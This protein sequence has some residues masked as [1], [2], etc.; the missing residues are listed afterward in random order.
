MN[1][2][3][4]SMTGVLKAAEKFAKSVSE[5]ASEKADSL[6][7]QAKAYAPPP[8]PTLNDIV[9]Q[10]E[11]TQCKLT[12]SLMDSLIASNKCRMC[13]RVFCAKCMSK[14]AVPVP[15]SLLHESFRPKISDDKPIPP[16]EK[17]SL[18]NMECLPLAVVACMEKFRKEVNEQ[19]AP[20]FDR[21]L[22]DEEQQDFFELPSAAPK[23]TAFR[24]A[25][26]F[27]QIAEKI[28]DFTS[29]SQ[30]LKAVK[31]AY[32]G[33][34]LINVLVAGDLFPVLS[35]MMEALKRF[36]ITGPMALLR[37]YYLGCKHT[38]LAKQRTQRRALYYLPDK[39]G[40]LLSSCPLPVLQYVSQYVSAAQW[41]YISRLPSPHEGNDWNS[42]YLAK[43]IARQGWTL[44]LCVNDSTKLINGAKCPAF[45][46][47]ARC[48]H[49]N[50]EAML[51]IRGS[52]STMDW[53]INFE[54][55]MTSY[56]Y[57]YYHED[58][59]LTV[60]D[61]M[62]YGV[63]K[64]SL[65]ILDGYH[66]RS[67]LNRLLD[68]GYDLKIV[69]H[70]LGGAVASCIAAELRSSRILQSTGSGQQAIKADSAAVFNLPPPT[71]QRSPS[72]CPS[73]AET[74]SL[75][76][77]ISAVL[78]SCPAYI[79]PAL[80][81]AF[82]EDR[83]LINVINGSD[84]VPRFCYH[85]LGLLAEE[86][87]EFLPQSQV[88]MEEDKED[89]KDYVSNMGR[90]GD[91][92]TATATEDHKAAR[93][94]RMMKA[95][96]RADK[97]TQQAAIAAAEATSKAQEAEASKAS[98]A[99]QAEAAAANGGEQSMLSGVRSYFSKAEPVPLPEGDVE[100]VDMLNQEPVGPVDEEAVQVAAQVK[101]VITVTPGPIVHLYRE[102]NGKLSIAFAL[103][104][105]F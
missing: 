44:L 76:Q 18:C 46:V 5:T 82:R 25:L 88:Y 70:S 14:S 101:D 16:D 19:F 64:G 4:S 3:M 62:H 17:Q 69:G 23:D 103:F 65:G 84:P 55:A 52:H 29:F 15:N 33:T 7:S 90:A 89:I 86:M 45:A 83:L 39:P 30:A 59:V 37:L 75:V 79:G 95:K 105:F 35:P 36:G 57:S 71:W 41:L 48:L 87:K 51:L 92:H 9:P 102:N 53:S 40:V 27:V 98:L 81:N 63:Y 26:R 32:Y 8:M 11:C 56:S 100:L 58:T 104:A 73:E 74:R 1:L 99:I 60:T 31:Y 77:R 93:M 38:L 54:E 28:A 10:A 68:H 72:Q 22:E 66:V 85:T 20:H 91:I 94:E 49:G 61:A 78:F 12:I 80:A 2:N 47:V 42:W 67:H 97:T 24:Q 21:F 13:S 6:L 50:K 34:T 43:M 96:D